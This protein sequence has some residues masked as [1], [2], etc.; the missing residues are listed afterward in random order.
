MAAISGFNLPAKH[1][2]LRDFGEPKGMLCEVVIAPP[3]IKPCFV[4][5]LQTC[6][7]GAAK[8]YVGWTTDLEGRLATH[9][10][11]KGAKSTRGRQWRLVHSESFKTRGA[12][13]AREY[14]LKRNKTER[15][16]LLGQTP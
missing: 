1:Y 4:Y 16:K 8:S 3:P 10:S 5:L 9:N 12:A 13:M 6:D 15:A 14:E 7:A 11:G 2:R